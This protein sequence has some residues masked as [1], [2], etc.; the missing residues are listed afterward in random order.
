MFEDILKKLR[1]SKIP[2]IVYQG[3]VF[4]VVKINE[5]KTYKCDEGCPYL[6]KDSRNCC[7][8]EDL[9]FNLKDKCFAC[10]SVEFNIIAT[11]AA[12]KAWYVRPEHFIIVDE[13]NYTYEGMTICRSV[14]KDK[15]YSDRFDYIHL[16]TQS[17]VIY[18]YQKPNIR[19][20]NIIFR[21]GDTAIPFKRDIKPL[22]TTEF[23]KQLESEYAYS[24]EEEDED[25]YDHSFHNRYKQEK[26]I[27]DI[28]Y[29]RVLIYKRL[30][31]DLLITEKQKIE[32]KI[33]NKTYGIY[34]TVKSNGYEN[35]SGLNPIIQEFRT[36]VEN[37][38]YR[39]EQIKKSEIEK[40]IKIQKVEELLNIEPHKFEHVCADL[41]KQQGYE[42]VKVTKRSNDKGVDI[43]CKKGFIKYVVQCKRYSNPVG[44][45]D[46]QMFIGAMQNAEADKG[47]YITTSKFTRE[48]QL[49]ASTNN[50]ELVD[51]L[52]LAEWIEVDADYI[53]EITL[54]D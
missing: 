38:E 45:Q 22:F 11:D 1:G 53:K 14:L 43:I 49:M 24:K 50:I 46:M 13:D 25:R 5:G 48:A 23:Y 36:E 34:L 21:D 4:S 7:H 35:Y 26:L 16:G 29:V 18:V 47:I 19:V 17:N 20:K 32:E 8:H 28:N 27:E 3:Y 9:K 44:S 12:N 54:F 39:L 37:Y 51:K 31:N 41:L 2:P 10:T 6:R 30:N 42:E 40:T 33:A 15:K 52:K